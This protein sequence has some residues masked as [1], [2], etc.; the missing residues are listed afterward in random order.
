MNA[1]LLSIPGLA[2]AAAGVSLF[3]ALSNTPALEAQ[4]MGGDRDWTKSRLSREEGAIY[5][6][7]FYGKKVTIRAKP[8]TDVFYRPDMQRYLGTLRPA[9]DLVLLAI[10]EKTF[11]VLGDAQQGQVSGWIPRAQVADA[12][13]ELI[14]K[15]V[16]AGQRHRAV[17]A[18]IA[19]GQVAVG[20]TKSEVREALG[21]PDS[22]ASLLD[23][24]G[25]T[26]EWTYTTYERRP[27]R[28]VNFDP[29]GFAFTT[30]V[31]VRQPVGYF[32]V[33]FENQ[34]VAR[35]A[36]TELLDTGPSGGLDIV[37]LPGGDRLLP[38]R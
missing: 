13:E 37:P 23:G 2:S 36:R 4:L 26:E 29:A 33:S 32:I 15:L 31:Y 9:Q 17:Q 18:L 14:A 20:M 25:Q 22:V 1:P 12:N 27:Q 10:A 19:D 16:E 24:A 6:D 28:V 8:G 3:L 35:A 34:L 21:E 5:L 38:L 7:D 30:T 11:R